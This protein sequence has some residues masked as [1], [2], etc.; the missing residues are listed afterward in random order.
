[1]VDNTNKRKTIC[2]DFVS[3]KLHGHLTQ[4][5][6]H[7]KTKQTEDQF[8]SCEET[9]ERE[10]EKGR[11]TR[12]PENR[13]ENKGEKKQQQKTNVEN[14]GGENKE[15]EHKGREQEEAGNKRRHRQYEV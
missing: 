2:K 5:A 10:R 3:P 15:R 7:L 12:R 4:H 11:E 1:L 13:G 9:K 14:T 8:F 6:Q